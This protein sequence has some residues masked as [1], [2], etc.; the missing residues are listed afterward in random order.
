[1]N[2]TCLLIIAHLFP[3]LSLMSQTTPLLPYPAP[4]DPVTWAG[5]PAQNRLASMNER[6]KPVL[7]K[8]LA[9]RGFTLG[10]E[11]FM[12]VFKESRE[13]ELWLRAGKATTFSLYR[14]YT[15]AAMSGTLGPKQ[16]EGDLQAPE[17]I[18]ATTKRL[19]NVDSRYHV[20]FNIGYP[21]ALDRHLQ[22]T[23]SLIMVHGRNVSI[24]CF[25]MTDPVIEEIFLIVKAAL[26]NGQSE[27]PVHCFPF[28]MT[29]DRMARAE[30]EQSPWLN[31]WQEIKLVYE[32]FE[33]TKKPPL[34]DTNSG[35]YVIQKQ[36]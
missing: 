10:D 28:R 33:Q 5:L 11:A 17:G 8:N 22:R 7:E 19:L 32:A 4:P 2:R 35:T 30:A 3:V 14:T 25:A 1:M 24:G 13:M 31:F 12:R 34:I 20:S 15:I 29:E 18:Y 21:N 23:G 9:A 27:V 36:K 26:E 6:V 16:K